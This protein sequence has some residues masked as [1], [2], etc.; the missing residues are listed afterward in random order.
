VPRFWAVR[1][2]PLYRGVDVLKTGF[3]SVA[4]KG[5]EPLKQAATRN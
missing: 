4:A 3:T 2:S 5:G 1:C